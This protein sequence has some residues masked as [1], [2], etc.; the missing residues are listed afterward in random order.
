MQK[1]FLCKRKIVFYL[2]VAVAGVALFSAQFF[3]TKKR[4]ESPDFVLFPSIQMEEV[5]KGIQE[6]SSKAEEIYQAAKNEINKTIKI[7]EEE[8]KKQLQ[9]EG[10]LDI[11]DVF[12]KEEMSEV[13]EE[14]LIKEKN[15]A[16]EE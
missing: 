15:E 1:T 5:T 14:K 9:E 2:V 11:E 10:T 16:E 6:R 4:A 3:I 7:D 12:Y 8:L 13:V